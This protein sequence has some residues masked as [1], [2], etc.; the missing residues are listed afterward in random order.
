[1]PPAST[2]IAAT[3]VGTGYRSNAV[4]MPTTIAMIATLTTTTTWKIILGTL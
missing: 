1:M 2:L 3:D 4:A